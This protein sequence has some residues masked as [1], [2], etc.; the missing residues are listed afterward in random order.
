MEIMLQT[1]GRVFQVCLGYRT[2][3]FGQDFFFSFVELWME[4]G[5]VTHAELLWHS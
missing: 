1:R 5:E 2:K 3:W 4:G